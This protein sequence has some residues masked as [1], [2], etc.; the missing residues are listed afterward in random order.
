MGV[1]DGAASWQMDV[2]DW[3]TDGE[4]AGMDDGGLLTAVWVD[5][6]VS[7]FSE[8]GRSSSSSQI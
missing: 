1:A 7:D 3:F 5:A 6:T 4:A 2:G 8:S